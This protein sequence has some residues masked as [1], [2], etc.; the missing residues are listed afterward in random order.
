M[1]TERERGRGI[2]WVFPSFAM[3]SRLLIGSGTVS[4]ALCIQLTTPAWVLC[5][6]CRPVAAWHRVWGLV[7]L[8]F[9]VESR[10]QG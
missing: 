1:N 2:Q 7:N 4:S 8:G 6:A 9:F 10:V 3:I 5:C